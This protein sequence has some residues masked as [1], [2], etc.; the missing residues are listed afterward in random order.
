MFRLIDINLVNLLKRLNTTIT[1]KGSHLY[2]YINVFY[3]GEVMDKRS[4]LVLI[5]SIY[6]L[7]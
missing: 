3:E 5:F 1:I 7:L 4:V 2:L 6:L